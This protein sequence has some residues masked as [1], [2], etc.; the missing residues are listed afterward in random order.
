MEHWAGIKYCWSIVMLL[1]GLV[2]SSFNLDCE[3]PDV[4]FPI[5][6]DIGHTV[7]CLPP[8]QLLES[9]LLPWVK[10]PSL[11]SSRTDLMPA[12]AITKPP[13]TPWDNYAK[14]EYHGSQRYCLSQDCFN[15]LH[16]TFTI[17]NKPRGTLD[18]SVTVSTLARMEVCPWWRDWC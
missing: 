3:H 1:L 13:Q 6:T 9:L 17:V 14:T 11:I 10:R 12:P 2:M 4:Q 7:I 18:D 8:K 15:S 16:Q 5:N